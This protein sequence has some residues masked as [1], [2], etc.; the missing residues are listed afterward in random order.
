MDRRCR[1]F[2]VLAGA[3][4]AVGAAAAPNDPERQSADISGAEVEEVVAVAAPLNAEAGAANAQRAVVD[5]DASGLD[6]ADFMRRELGSVFVNEAQGNPLQPDVQYRGFVGSPLLG[7]PQGIAV[8]QDAMRVNEPFGDTV[9]WALIPKSAIDRVLLLP[10]GNPLFGLNALGGALA[11]RTKDGFAH[12][13]AEA[14]LSGGDFGRRSL[15][16]EVGGEFGASGG[17]FATAAMLRED[18]WRDYSP[19]DSRQ[20]FAKL[21]WRGEAA[22]L[23][24][25]AT[26]AETDLVGNGAAPTALLAARRAA[27]FTRPDRTRNDLSALNLQS[28]TELGRTTLRIAAYWRHSDIATY[29]GDDSD[30]EAC[31]HDATLLCL[32]EEEGEEGEEDDHG[33]A[34]ASPA[35]DAAGRPIP[36]L[37][38][39]VGATVNRT[40][41]AQRGAGFSAQAER[42]AAWGAASHRLAVGVGYHRASSVFR[43]GTEL[44]RL[45]ATR[46]AVAGGV[47]LGDAFTHVAAD[48]ASAAIYLSDSVQ[49]GERLRLTAAV[50]YGRAKVALRDRLGTELDGSHR[51]RRVNPA[52]GATVQLT[53]RLAAYAAYGEANRAPSPVELTCADPEAPC[54]LPN[55]FVA[56]PPLKQVVAR[57][58]EAG[59]RGRHDAVAWRLG[60]FDVDSDDDILF[61]SAGALT[62]QGYFDN[63]GSTRRQ[64]L[65]LSLRSHA[66]EARL[67][68]F[69]HATW[70][71]AT[72]EDAFAVP[73]V[74]H[75]LATEGELAVAA[76]RRLPLVPGRLLKAGTTVRLH[77]RLTAKASLLA[78]SAQRLRGDE[79]NLAP[80]LEGYKVLNLRLDLRLTPRVSA[81]AEVDNALD[82]RYATF[83][84]FGDA[85]D[86]LGDGF[87]GSRFVT[88][89]APR[90]VWLGV[91]ARR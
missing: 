38:A 90:G 62:S 39:L 42:Q 86:V 75:P 89:A 72:F 8:Y 2:V 41:T 83:G 32:E 54:R 46:Q 70:L 16:G 51:F 25:S 47:F 19:S 21:S 68:W 74:H 63:V 44:G 11:V 73:A 78:A 14:A 85:E 48:A 43:A 30:Y 4:V 34:D 3:V 22:S 27:I 76:G 40:R 35:L 61:I 45:D 13:G 71:R 6:L 28:E 23:D 20:A 65:E 82:Q 55:A 81:F 29:N 26:V 64:G 79:A 50:R 49:V 53:P 18:G 10:G 58:V 87:D 77:P 88:P 9:N 57:T 33:A 67:R 36:A 66:A 5:A 84:V 12:P 60:A 69:L 91:V 52:F 1:N 24:A 17:Y 15:A 80:P 59:L 31:A 37:A 56:D 7:L